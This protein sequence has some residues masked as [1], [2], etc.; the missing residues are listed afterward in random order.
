MPETLRRRRRLPHVS[1][2]ELVDAA[3]AFGWVDSQ[4]RKVDA[5]HSQLLMTPRSPKS[6]WSRVNKERVARLSVAGLMHPA[7]EAMVA[8]AKQAGTWSAL[9]EVENLTEPADLRTAL[10]TATDAR[11]FWDQFSR[12]TKRAILEWINPAKRPATRTERIDDTVR[13][14]AQNIRANPPRHPKRR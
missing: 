10:C 7:G 1:C 4:P 13:L 3:I 11:Q 2:D 6:N 9:D 14:A 12:S 8:H 5:D